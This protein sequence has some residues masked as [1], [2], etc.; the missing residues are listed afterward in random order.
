MDVGV[1]CQG[2]TPGVEHGGDA[3]PGAQ[4]FWI[5]GDGERGLGTRL[6]QQVVDHALVLIGDLGDPRWQGE[7]QV[8]VSD[9]QQFGL[10]IGQPAPG[11]RALA[12][13]AVAIAAGVIGDVAMAAVLTGRHMATERRGATALDRTHHLHLL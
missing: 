6:E 1:V 5:G 3:D 13:G 7:D 11:R 2:R 4:V 9:G 12:F 8:E 10:A